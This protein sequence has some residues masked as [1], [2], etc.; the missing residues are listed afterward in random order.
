MVCLLSMRTN[1]HDIVDAAEVRLYYNIIL[2]QDG[3]GTRRR[4][5]S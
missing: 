2:K 4:Q 5:S 1:A 3:F